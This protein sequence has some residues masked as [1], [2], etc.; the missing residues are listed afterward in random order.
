VA[1]A[2]PDAVYLGGVLNSNGAAVLRALRRRL[3]DEPEMLL[4]DGFTPTNLLMRQ[5][6]VAADGAYLS[7]SG[8][9]NESLEARGRRFAA[10]LRAT[11]PGVDIEPSAIYTAEATRVLLDAIGRSDGTRA[12]VISVPRYRTG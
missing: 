6:G 8:L 3:G 9:I 4:S 1:H 2:R 7:I 12:S 10:A 11:L 5:A